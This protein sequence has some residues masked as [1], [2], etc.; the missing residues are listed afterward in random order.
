MF[1]LSQV[2]LCSCAVESVLLDS[3]VT[4]SPSCERLHRQTVKPLP[5]PVSSLRPRI[6]LV[7]RTMAPSQLRTNGANT[8]KMWSQQR[9]KNPQ[10]SVVDFANTNTVQ[11]LIVKSAN[12]LFLFYHCLSKVQFFEHGFIAVCPKCNFS[13]TVCVA[14]FSWCI[15]KYCL[16]VL[17][18]MLV[19]SN[20]I[21][22][23]VCQ[24]ATLVLLMI[25]YTI[26][27]GSSQ[28][29]LLLAGKRQWQ[30]SNCGLFF[31]Q[32]QLHFAWS[33]GSCR[34]WWHQT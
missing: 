15:F 17:Y 32:Q 34:D 22:V 4:R 14:V 6:C 16:Q 12:V 8:T 11:L 13:N 21:C 25:A 24:S 3:H 20:T 23:T 2:P 30:I 5:P 9:Q 33:A 1:L 10:T 19:F 7:G 28:K 27:C 29:F 18:G 31:F 26:I